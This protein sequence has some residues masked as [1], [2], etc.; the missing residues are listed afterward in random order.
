[1][2]KDMTKTSI[3]IPEAIYK[4]ARE[5]TNN[6]S[7]LVA[8][9]LERYI[10]KQIEKAKASFGKWQ[11]RDQPSVEIVNILRAEERRTDARCSR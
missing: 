11:E 6:F 10:E 4:Q 8:M 2:D 5:L 3:T 7:G 1:M 9:A